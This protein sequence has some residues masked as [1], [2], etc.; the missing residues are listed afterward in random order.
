MSVGDFIGGMAER[1]GN[2]VV[3]VDLDRD[4]NQDGDENTDD[5]AVRNASRGS[6]AVGRGDRN[7]LSG[8]RAKRAVGDSCRAGSD[9]V[10]QSGE[11]SR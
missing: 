3:D 2:S 4:I 6:R 7:G 11:D 10:G 5:N 1:T 9:S 8:D